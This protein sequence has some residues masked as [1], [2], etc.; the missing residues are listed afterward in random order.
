MNILYFKYLKQGVSLEP[1][2][3]VFH[4]KPI[5]IKKDV[6]QIPKPPLNKSIR[7]P[8]PIEDPDSTQTIFKLDMSV[9]P[10]E[11]PEED[12][13]EPLPPGVEFEEEYQPI[14]PST[15]KVDLD[16]PLP[17][18]VEEQE[19]V[20]LTPM[21]KHKGVSVRVK[22]KF[23]DSPAEIM[24]NKILDNLDDIKNKSESKSVSSEAEATSVPENVYSNK[25]DDLESPDSPDLDA[26]T[27][28]QNQITE[29][30]K[31]QKM[32]E[33]IER[34]H[35]YPMKHRPVEE[36]ESPA[37]PDIKEQVVG[38]KPSQGDPRETALDLA[39]TSSTIDENRSGA[40]VKNVEA[41]V[42]TPNQNDEGSD[43]PPPPP[44][45]TVSKV[46]IDLDSD[47]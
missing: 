18:G 12:T 28:T 27:S 47:P 24:L 5:T 17:P 29:N 13:S 11:L 4:F 40:F 8:E 33:T 25:R 23:T 46:V 37:S 35:L 16:E 31:V 38:A 32:L 9:P 39:V 21:K 42:E 3:P 30:L 36:S 1:V 43:L 20:Q 15:S 22:R 19:T 7:P 2:Q 10:P 45:F 34:E 44:S 26:V 6:W 14:V 41:D